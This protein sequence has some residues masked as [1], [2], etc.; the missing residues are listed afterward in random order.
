MLDGALAW[1]VAL[2]QPGP[3]QY[4]SC[5][6]PVRLCAPP[7][8][9]L[10]SA[11]TKTIHKNHIVNVPGP[12]FPHWENYVFEHRRVAWA[13]PSSYRFSIISKTDKEIT[14]GKPVSAPGSERA[15]PSTWRVSWLKWL[16]VTLLVALLAVTVLAAWQLATSVM[17]VL[18]Q[19]PAIPVS[20]PID[21]IRIDPP[22]PPGV[23]LSGDHLQ[24]AVRVKD[25]DLAIG[26]YHLLTWLPL[27][28]V[29]I[30]SFWWMVRLLAAGRR[31]DRS[32]FSAQTTR[33]LR[34]IGVVQLVG[35][36]VIWL[37]ANTVQD[38]L[39]IH[40]L[41]TGAYYGD[42]PPYV[43]TGNA[44]IGL[45]ALAVSE[46]IRKGQNMLEDLEGTV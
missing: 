34:L 21:S 36:L 22:L 37:T 11:A 20:I 17:L 43:F 10:V 7:L 26:I 33:N 8:S 19:G 44:L 16:H 28:A 5:S 39:S 9:H 35:A 15:L 45:S 13:Y 32:L 38:T 4:G 29:N 25:G 23:E 1:P 14:M 41:G 46:I 24:A 40:V 42:L 3:S 31:S 6:P 30:L 2:L 12:W 27:A 18:G